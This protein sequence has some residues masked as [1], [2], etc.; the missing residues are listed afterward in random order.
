[1]RCKHCGGEISLEAAYCS[2]CGQPNEQAMGHA[3]ELNKFRRAFESTRSAVN[4]RVQRFTGASVRIVI[5]ALLI[6]AIFLLLIIGG[7]AYSV[8][9]MIVQGRTERNA[10]KVMAQMDALLEA[11][12]FLA[13][14]AFCDENYVDCF[15]NA[16]EKYAPAERAAAAF[17]YAYRDIMALAA[18]ADYQSPDDILPAL[19][20]DLE[21]FYNAADIGEYEHYE[22]A[23]NAL[24]RNALAAMEQRISLLLMSYC[25]LTEQE[26]AAL[27]DM[28]AV[29]RGTILEEAM[30]HGE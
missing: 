26:A 22:G 9:R 18:P 2:Y 29:G 8:R 15:D 24:N 7:R 3:K 27:R 4:T 20:D 17:S 30:A 5:I 25:N 13:F 19:A 11:E 1:M 21:Y 14:N 28:S 6:L 12:E 10:E 16:F 23:D